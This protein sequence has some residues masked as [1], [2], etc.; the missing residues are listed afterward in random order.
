MKYWKN[1]AEGRIFISVC[2]VMVLLS[3]LVYIAGD[4]VYA[5]EKI[6][7]K[8]VPYFHQRWHFD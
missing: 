8:G 4:R 7:L 5:Q 2:F 3:C 6:I 1:L